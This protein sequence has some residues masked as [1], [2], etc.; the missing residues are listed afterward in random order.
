MKRKL[1]I[2]KMRRLLLIL[3]TMILC[4]DAI[5]GE[6]LFDDAERFVQKRFGVRRHVA[7]AQ[8]ALARMH[9]GRQN[10]I[11]VNAAVEQRL[12]DA[13]RGLEVVRIKRDDR[14]GALAD[15]DALAL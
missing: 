14:R 8:H 2:Q 5:L 7:G 3:I 4:S 6:H 9:G 13:E 11:H 1:T 10:G 15:R 12:F